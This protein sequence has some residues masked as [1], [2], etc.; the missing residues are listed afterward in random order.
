M[1]HFRGRRWEDAIKLFST[2]KNDPLARMLEAKCRA[3]T[4]GH[5]SEWQDVWV[6]SGK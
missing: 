2:F 6:L 4:G 5:D 1:L 3:L